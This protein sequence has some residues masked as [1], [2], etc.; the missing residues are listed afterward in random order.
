[1]GGI[2]RAL[3]VSKPPRHRDENAADGTDGR[4]NDDTH[5][6]DP[7]KHGQCESD[8]GAVDPGGR[9][10]APQ[11]DDPCDG[12]GTV[13][14]EHARTR[15]GVSP[16]RNG[17]GDP[18]VARHI[19][20]LFE[21][22]DFSVPLART[23]QLNPSP[24]EHGDVTDGEAATGRGSAPDTA[25]GDDDPGR[26]SLLRRSVAR[27]LGSD[28]YLLRSYA[29]VATLL[30]ALVVLTVVLALPSWIAATAQ[31][32]NVNKLSRAF[33]LLAGGLVV[34]GLFA[35]MGY[36]A[37]RH[38][39]GTATRRR[40]ALFG[41]SGYLFVASLYLAMLTSAPPRYR[42]PPPAAIEPIVTAL[43]ALDP[44]YGI[45]FPALAAL[46]VVAVDRV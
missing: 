4:R 18:A 33:L 20:N 3:R 17:A 2:P 28:S 6:D 42:D 7:R 11:Q 12:E 14:Q 40:D 8:D 37:R 16:E 22:R 21:S 35:P 39:R 10:L 44:A 38:R 1:M 13:S 30:G 36:A 26:Y 24:P 19:P 43:Y 5:Q 32:S 15:E 31:A 45:A 25:S 29:V 27:A 9:P 23:A 41:L 34:A 46:V